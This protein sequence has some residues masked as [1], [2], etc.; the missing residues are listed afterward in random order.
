[1]H[2]RTSSWRL[3]NFFARSNSEVF[4]EIYE[5]R[6]KAPSNTSAA[7]GEICDEVDLRCRVFLFPCLDVS[8]EFRSSDVRKI[9][10]RRWAYRAAC[11][12]L[13]EV[14]NIFRIG[15]KLGCGI[16][17]PDGLC[18]EYELERGKGAIKC[19][20]VLGRRY[21]SRW[22]DARE[23]LERMEIIHGLS[24]SS[25]VDGKLVVHSSSEDRISSVVS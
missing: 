8:A 13:E 17:L 7:P 21:L 24:R 19:S 18:D 23:S 5:S 10:D 6:L 14:G 15:C 16:V 9:Y 12:V 4:S 3:C 2:L 1:M 11:I 20:G 25:M 22:E